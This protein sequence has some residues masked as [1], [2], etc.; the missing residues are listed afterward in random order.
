M[1]KRPPSLEL[2]WH[3]L[4]DV[5]HEWR[6][7]RDNT[8]AHEDDHRRALDV[9]LVCRAARALCEE[10]ERLEELR[11]IDVGCLTAL[12]LDSECACRYV[13]GVGDP[14]AFHSSA[15]AA[16]VTQYRRGMAKREAES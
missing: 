16:A 12:E 10:R 14:C 13:S 3:Q 2:E 15:I 9:L 5:E 11:R 8:E 1:N 4:A 6:A 7:I